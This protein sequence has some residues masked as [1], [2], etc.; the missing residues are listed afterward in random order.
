MIVGFAI[1]LVVHGLIHLIGFAKAFELAELPQLTLP[2]SRWLGAGWLLA[3]LL[4]LAAA[5]TLFLWPRGW[6]AIAV[7]AVV[8]SM[9]VIVPSWSDAKFG[10]LG[11]LIVAIGIARIMR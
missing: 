7:C 8:V 6:R 1:V 3:A 9:F 4:F 11:N 10:V 2:I 5:A